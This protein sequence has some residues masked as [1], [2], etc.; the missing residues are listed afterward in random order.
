MYGPNCIRRPALERVPMA[1][2]AARLPATL[3]AADHGR[4][5]PFDSGHGFPGL[6]PDLTAAAERALTIHRDETLQYSGRA[7]LADMRA[8]IAAHLGEQGA[9]VGPDE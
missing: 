7:G 6:F 2:R 3:A 4:S 8:W 1:A 5:I 9:E